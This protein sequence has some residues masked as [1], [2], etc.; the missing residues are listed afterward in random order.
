MGLDVNSE[1]E[2]NRLDEL[3]VAF[4]SAGFRT[5]SSVSRIDARAIVA[6]N[7]ELK[8]LG[9]NELKL[10]EELSLLSN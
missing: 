4:R 7:S 1:K 9:K 2:K 8:A 10:G 3:I 5:L 6:I